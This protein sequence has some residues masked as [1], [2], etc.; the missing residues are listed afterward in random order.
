MKNKDFF[1]ERTHFSALALS[2]TRITLASLA[3]QTHQNHTQCNLFPE[4][5]QN[6][7]TPRAETTPPPRPKTRLLPFSKQNSDPYLQPPFSLFDL[8]IHQSADS[9]AAR[10]G[11][12]SRP[13]IVEA[14]SKTRR[15]Q[16][17]PYQG[18]IA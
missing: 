8:Q 10:F 15:D 4:Q 18:E 1:A 17:Y 3:R 7:P 16:R 12:S 13:T 2:K 11:P 9:N 6:E 5:P 14:A